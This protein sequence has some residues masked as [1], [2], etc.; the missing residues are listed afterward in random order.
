MPISEENPMAETTRTTEPIKLNLGSGPNHMPGYVN[1][2]IKEGHRINDLSAYA[3]DS[4]DEIRASHVLEHESHTKT[5]DIVRHWFN[6]LKPGG[7]VKIAVPNLQYIVDQMGAAGGKEP[8]EAFLMG[9]HCDADDYHKSVFTHAKLDH[10]LRAIGFDCVRTWEPDFNDCSALPVSLNMMAE[11]PNSCRLNN[12]CCV[13]SIP[14]LMFSDNVVSMIGTIY[15]SGMSFVAQQGAF[16]GQCLERT[17]EDVIANKPNVTH[18]LTCD[19]DS[20]FSTD[21]VMQLY[22]TMQRLGADAIFP[23]QIKRQAS[24]ALL[25]VLDEAGNIRGRLTAAEA[26]SDGVRVATGHFGLTLISI[27]KLKALPKPWFME[28]PDGEGGWG[29]ERVGEDGEKI[30]GRTDP[31]IF[32]WRRWQDAGNSLYQANHV[33]IGHAQLMATFPDRNWNPVHVHTSD[34]QES[35]IPLIAR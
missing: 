19:Y 27:E 31:D 18:V 23:V 7:I 29:L 12:V 16:W 30:A 33:R 1:L 26:R 20:I 14:R 25:T 10:I 15:A 28:V 34:I 2:D 21:Q 6:K 17:I 24:E 35:G 8:L 5:L 32:F 13:M 22:R 3:D 4:V 11:K 9:G